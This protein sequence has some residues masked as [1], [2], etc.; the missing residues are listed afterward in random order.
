MLCTW[1]RERALWKPSLTRSP[2]IY[3]RLFSIFDHNVRLPTSITLTNGGLNC[4]S[5]IH[6]FERGS[7]F[8][9]ARVAVTFFYLFFFMHAWISSHSVNLVI[10]GLHLN[11]YQ[12]RSADRGFSL[13]VELWNKQPS[14]RS[15]CLKN[16]TSRRKPI[17][18]RLRRKTKISNLCLFLA[19]KEIF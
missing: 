3:I 2:Q 9:W 19:N 12:L 5:P 8:V 18:P 10:S 16:N 17:I 4:F 7:E 11:V 1:M 6:K 14:L 13:T 15:D